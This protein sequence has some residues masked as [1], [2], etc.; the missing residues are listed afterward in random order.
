MPRVAYSE[1]WL[2][3]YL[4]LG[5]GADFPVSE[6]V[7][8]SMTWGRDFEG[9]VHRVPAIILNGS[10]CGQVIAW[11]GYDRCKNGHTWHNQSG[12]PVADGHFPFYDGNGAYAE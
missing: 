12:E 8:H 9:L 6:A 7:L 1:A 2:H 11:H 3:T 5:L 10:P 4:L